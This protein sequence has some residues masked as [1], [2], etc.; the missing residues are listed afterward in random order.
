[1]VIYFKYSSVYMSVPNSQ[2]NCFLTWFSNLR[3]WDHRAVI[4]RFFSQ[5]ILFPDSRQSG[6]VKRMLWGSLDLGVAEA[7]NFPLIVIPLLLDSDVNIS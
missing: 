2:A 5:R 6:A 1:M 3:A 7:A 4:S